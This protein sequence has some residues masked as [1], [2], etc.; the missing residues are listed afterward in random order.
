MYLSSPLLNEIIVPASHDAQ[1]FRCEGTPPRVQEKTFVKVE[2]KAQW[3]LG[4]SVWAPRPYECEAKAFWD[5]EE[6]VSSAFHADWSLTKLARP[7]Q[8]VIKD[9]EELLRVKD[10]MQRHYRVVTDLM[11]EM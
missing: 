4:L 3:S 9:P 5:T 8:R 2:K 1:H 11:V 6:I 10:T 7:D